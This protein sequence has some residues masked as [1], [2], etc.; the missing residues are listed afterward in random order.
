M[1]YQYTVFESRDGYA[2]EKNAPDSF[3]ELTDLL[4]QCENISHQ[5]YIFHRG[6]VLKVQ[7]AEN[8]DSG[9]RLSFL[10]TV[11][12]FR[13]EDGVFASDTR[14]KA[15]PQMIENFLTGCS[16]FH[17]IEY[18]QNQTAGLLQSFA[19]HLPEDLISGLVIDEDS[20]QNYKFFNTSH[21]K[22]IY[23]TESLRFLKKLPVFRED[24]RIFRALCF[25]YGAPAVS[26]L[27]FIAM[28][29]SGSE[30]Q[31]N[32]EKYFDQ[33]MIEKAV[34]YLLLSVDDN[35]ISETQS[36]SDS[37]IVSGFG[38]ESGF[39]SL[40]AEKY[41]SV[42]GIHEIEELREF[43]HLFA[44]FRISP[45][46]LLPMLETWEQEY[47]A[48]KEMPVRYQ[49]SVILTYPAFV[50]AVQENTG[51]HFITDDISYDT[52]DDIYAYILEKEIPA[53]VLEKLFQENKNN[54]EISDLL[55]FVSWHEH[56]EKKIKNPEKNLLPAMLYWSELVSEEEL[57][58]Y[59]HS[60]ETAEHMKE[61]AC[62]LRI[63]ERIR[64]L[65]EYSRSLLLAEKLSAKYR[66]NTLFQKGKLG[67]T[68]KRI[69]AVSGTAFLLILL[70]CIRLV[71]VMLYE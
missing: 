30:V 33:N 59:Y 28:L 52:I 46:L 6:N 15:W 39:V 36:K 57:E 32:Y 26:M 16:P 1:I 53:P 55:H 34:E 41:I 63:P 27:E 42:Y 8:P 47:H 20:R 58:K 60:Q 19:R 17:R 29:A 21:K 37:G 11:D 67:R 40:M 35:F 22:M 9:E 48:I 44:C 50:R 38:I 68:E 12:D 3:S 25:R 43:L 23:D 2:W 14:N 18:S 45:E 61:E 65:P 66:L 64:N 70:S 71:M 24:N 5:Y 13:N 51:C 49:D 31:K 10:Y 62:Q 54:T 69:L 7:K 4:M 56:P